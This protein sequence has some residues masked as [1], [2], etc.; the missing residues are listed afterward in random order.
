M[1]TVYDI[2][3]LEPKNTVRENSDPVFPFFRR[4]YSSA[5]SALG[6]HLGADLRRLPQQLAERGGTQIFELNPVF[7]PYQGPLAES[8][9][10]LETRKN[11]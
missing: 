2:K 10:Q 4:C 8:S 1:T 5:N 9:S 11:R 3:N 7:S 6:E